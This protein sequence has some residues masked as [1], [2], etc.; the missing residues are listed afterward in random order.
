MTSLF[1]ARFLAALVDGQ[2]AIFNGHRQDSHRGAVGGAE[3]SVVP[4]SGRGLVVQQR[5]V[6][7]RTEELPVVSAELE[8]CLR[9][10]VERVE[11]VAA[12]SPMGRI[13]K[14]EVAGSQHLRRVML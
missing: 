12:L 13:A 8:S 11:E 10:V 1:V 9:T 14:Q 7:M 5:L 4:G 3:L 6:Q 2:E